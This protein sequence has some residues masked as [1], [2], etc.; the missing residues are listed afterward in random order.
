[1]QCIEVIPDATV[2]GMIRW[3][4]PLKEQRRRRRRI[5]AFGTDIRSLTMNFRTPCSMRITLLNVLEQFKR[6]I[7]YE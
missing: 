6:M 4:G 5:T 1:M 2:H 7:F 3:L